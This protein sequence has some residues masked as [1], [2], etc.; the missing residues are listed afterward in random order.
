MSFEV[1]RKEMEAEQG[2]EREREKCQAMKPLFFYPETFHVG[3]R[4]HHKTTQM[5]PPNLKLTVYTV[6]LV[7]GQGYPGR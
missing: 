6:Y 1:N 2:R 7:F 3:E 4:S 5:H